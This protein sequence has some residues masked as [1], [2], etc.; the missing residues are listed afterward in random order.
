MTTNAHTV[1]EVLVLHR[2]LTDLRTARTLPPDGSFLIL[3]ANMGHLADAMANSGKPEVF[4]AA[5]AC[6]IMALRIGLDGDPAWDIW[7]LRHGLDATAH[8]VPFG[9]LPKFMTTS[10]GT[11]EAGGEK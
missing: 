5:I 7:R 11:G 10:G 6:A 9:D 2:L 1:E 3:Q 4:D 8:G